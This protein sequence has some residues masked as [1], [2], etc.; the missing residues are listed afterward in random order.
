MS[1]YQAG[2]DP[3]SDVRQWAASAEA[4]TL[5]HPPLV[6]LGAP[7]LLD[8]VTLLPGARQVRGADGATGELLLAPK[9]PTNLSYWDAKTTA[10]F[11]KRALRKRGEVKQVGATHAFVARTIWPKDFVLDPAKVEARPLAPKETLRSFVQERG[12]TSNLKAIG[13][14]GYLAA[15]DQS[16]ARGRKI[17][18]YLTEEQVRLCPAVAFEAAGHDLMQLVG[19]APAL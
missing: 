19:A 3:V 16:L 6:W 1:G 18:D 8:N 15:R 13:A 2:A 7:Q 4:A 11:G 9:I 14:Y 12:A 5:A 17:Y 10:F